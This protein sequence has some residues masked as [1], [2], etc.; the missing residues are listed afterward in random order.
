MFSLSDL[1]GR[2][3][4][5]LL[6]VQHIAQQG[7]ISAEVSAIQIVTSSRLHLSPVLLC[8]YSASEIMNLSL[9]EL[10]NSHDVLLDHN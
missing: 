6:L 8:F 5:S 3:C 9:Q 2:D 1:L 4:L 10:K 7:L